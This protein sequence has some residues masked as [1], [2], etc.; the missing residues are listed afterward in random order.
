MGKGKKYWS[1]DSHERAY[2]RLLEQINNPNKFNTYDNKK[3]NLAKITDDFP[4]Y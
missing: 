3:K 1:K 2:E 4:R